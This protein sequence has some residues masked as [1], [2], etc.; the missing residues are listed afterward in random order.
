MREPR[1]D[2]IDAICINRSD[3]GDGAAST[4][5]ARTTTAFFQQIDW[6]PPARVVFGA[7]N[8]ADEL[9]PALRRRLTTEIVFE[10][11][12]REGRRRMLETWLGKAPIAPKQL[13]KLADDTEGLAGAELRARAMAMARR[14]VMA[15]PDPSE[16]FRVVVDGPAQ[17]SLDD[18]DDDMPSKRRRSVDPDRADDSEERAAKLL[19]MLD[20]FGDPLAGTG[21]LFTKGARR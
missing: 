9:D 17:T 16:R 13:D 21:N 5:N 11:P 7:T 12:D 2:E 4:E 14:A 15:Q 10:A 20:G 6:L 19:K 3:A 1:L 8:F 18:V